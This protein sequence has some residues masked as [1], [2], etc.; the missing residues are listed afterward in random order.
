MYRIAICDDDAKIRCFLRRTIEGFGLFCIVDEFSDGME[1]LERN[2]SYDI[3][4]LD[5]DMPRMNG[6]ETAERL[7]KTDR[8]VKII[9]VTGYQ[10][11]MS[12]SFAVHPFS[13]LI[14]PVRQ[15]EILRQVREALL[16]SGAEVQ[17]NLLRFQTT[18]G[19][20]EF[21]ASDIYYLEYQSRKL[22]FVT[23]QGESMV[24]GKISEY[25]E[26]LAPHGFASPHKSFTVNLYHVKAIRGYDIIMMNGD[27]V[28][29]SQKRSAQFRGLLGKY[30]ADWL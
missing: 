14:K 17:E 21:L 6:I 18:E 29:L 26:K 22:R 3:L 10:D 8:R 9:Y 2:T 25:L 1:V 5:I 24:R 30:Q 27:W 19:M 13:F 23:K 16:Y 7:R 15:E 11:Y 4:F 28:P 20:E 12:R